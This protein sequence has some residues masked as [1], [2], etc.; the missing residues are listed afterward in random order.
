MYNDVTTRYRLQ[1]TRLPPYH[2]LNDPLSL[3]T[4]TVIT[5]SCRLTDVLIDPTM[6]DVKRYTFAEVSKRDGSKGQ[7][8]W[9]VY[10]DSVYDL[11]KYIDEHPGGYDT[12]MED[13]GKDCTRN[14]D[15]VGHTTDALIL[16]AKYKIGEIVEEE[17]RYDENGKKKKKVL[18]AK[19]DGKPT[20]RSCLGVITCGLLG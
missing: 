9:T 1:L 10:R 19:P 6:M 16:L 2:C 18:P 5:H 7:P 4:I 8:L 14:F 11:T 17:K 13:A 12:I 20:S 15:D 3:I